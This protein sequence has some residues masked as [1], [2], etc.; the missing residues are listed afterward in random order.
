MRQS[1]AVT[2]RG[3]V[4]LSAKFGIW[5]AQLPA[6]LLGRVPLAPIDLPVRLRNIRFQLLHCPLP[7]RLYGDQMSHW[8]AEAHDDEVDIVPPCLVEDLLHI[9]P[10]GTDANRAGLCHSLKGKNDP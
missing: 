4:A 9:R 6:N 10:E 1:C 3:P 8:L 7:P 5:Q 2:A